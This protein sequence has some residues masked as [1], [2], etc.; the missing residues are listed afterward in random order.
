M[1]ITHHG[2]GIIFVTWFT[3]D[4]AG[5]P[6]WYVASN[7]PIATNT[8]TGTLYETSGPPFGPTFNSAAVSIFPVGSITLT[9]TGQNT[10]TMSYVLNG[11]S[12]SKAITRQGF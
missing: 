4:S 10:G 3:Y 2:T 1:T 11:M 7:C 12:G 8:C 6:K 5:K 9:F